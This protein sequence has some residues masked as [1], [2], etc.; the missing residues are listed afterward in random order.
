MAKKKGIYTGRKTGTTKARPER[1]KELKELGLT[2]NE[3]SNSLGVTEYTVASY[4]EA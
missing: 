4:L 2:Y 1:A 3:I